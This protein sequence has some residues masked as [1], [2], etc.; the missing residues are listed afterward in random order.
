MLSQVA[1]KLI[2]TSGPG[3]DP[4]DPSKNMTLFQ[5]DKNIQFYQPFALNAIDPSR[6]LPSIPGTHDRKRDKTTATN[7]RPN[8]RGGLGVYR[9][10][11]W[12]VA[13]LDIVAPC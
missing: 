2:I 13:H 8:C 11:H 9:R 7:R 12:I 1:V 4:A 10:A 6:M 5:F 3:S